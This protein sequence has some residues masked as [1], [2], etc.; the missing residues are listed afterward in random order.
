MRKPSRNANTSF[1]SLWPRMALLGAV[2]TSGCSAAGQNMREWAPATPTLS[3]ENATI[4][5]V[6]VYLEDHGTQWLLGQVQPGRR[7][8]LRLPADVLAR[9]EW[10]VT[11]VAIPLG[12]R[13]D[14]MRGGAVADAIRLDLQPNESL[15][16]TRWM[17]RGRLLVSASPPRGRR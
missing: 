15:T 5:N 12:T 10:E 14:G 9:T 7:T 8:L 4:D 13:K 16:T 1:V 3:F 17:L 6:A 11:L 2:A